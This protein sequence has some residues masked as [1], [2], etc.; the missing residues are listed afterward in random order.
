MP[1]K[2]EKENISLENFPKS[3]HAHFEMTVVLMHHKPSYRMM[4]NSL[5]DVNAVVLLHY[6]YVF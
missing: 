6:C 4:P 3:D 2:N 5:G 1:A